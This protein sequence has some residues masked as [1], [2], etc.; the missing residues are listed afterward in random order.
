MENMVNVSERPFQILG[1]LCLC[2][3]FVGVLRLIIETFF[4]IQILPQ[5]TS[6]LILNVLIIGFLGIISVLSA[7]GEFTIRN[8]IKLQNAPAF[9]VREIY[10]RSLKDKN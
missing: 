3:A 6:G 1:I 8:F 7:I 5:V 9:I 2:V 10:E 4:P